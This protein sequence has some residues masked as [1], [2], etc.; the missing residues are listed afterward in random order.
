MSADTNKAVVRAIEEAW[1]ENR[2]DAL[3][4]LFTDNFVAHTAIPGMPPGIAGAKMAHAGSMQ[5]FPDRRTSIEDLLADG[6][7]V[8]AR[9]RMTGTNTGGL[10]WMGIPANG[11]TVSTEWISIYRLADGK[12]VE[13]RAVM[14]I[15]GM[16]QQLGAIPTPGQ[17]A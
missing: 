17:G 7:Q 4:D 10:P 8:V 9:I 5:A 2:L 14:D 12:V 15:L 16:L 13:H 1:N 11:R 6:D 3:D